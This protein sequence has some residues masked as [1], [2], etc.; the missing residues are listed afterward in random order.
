MVVD[1]SGVAWVSGTTQSTDFPL[2]NSERRFFGRG[3]INAFVARLGADGKVEDIAMIG[4]ATSEGLVVTPEGKVYLAGTKS[5]SE[6]KHF[7][8]VAEI[9]E[10]GGARILTLG[11]GTADGRGSLFAVGF[12]GLGAFIARV[13]LAAWKQTAFRSIGAAD[14]DRARAT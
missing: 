8:F 10:K 1:T 13:G 6:E 12:N 14:A 3:A 9:Q 11:P 4:D 2:K 7:A 5:P